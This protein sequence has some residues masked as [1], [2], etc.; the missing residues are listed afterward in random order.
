MR[1]FPSISLEYKEDRSN[2]IILIIPSPNLKVLWI[3]NLPRHGNHAIKILSKNLHRLRYHGGEPP[4]FVPDIIPS[5]DEAKFDITTGL[6]SLNNTAGNNHWASKILMDLCNV[7]KL[8]LGTFYLEPQAFASSFVSY[9]KSSRSHHFHVEKLSKSADSPYI[10]PEYWKTQELS[11]D[12]M[13]KQ[14]R[15]VEIELFEGSEFEL[16]LVKFLLQN[17]NI[18]KKMDVLLSKKYQNN[19]ASSSSIKEKIG[20]FARVSPYAAVSVLEIY[21]GYL[22]VFVPLLVVI[23]SFGASSFRL[24]SDRPNNLFF[25]WSQIWF[26]IL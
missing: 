18:Q 16:A 13:L 4:S 14:L 23:S 8:H 6:H 22:M 1:Y 10:H 15:T 3:S 24:H 5:L 11:T 17:A 21:S 25:S 2:D 12:G 9:Q 20:M 19:A 26:K 7:T